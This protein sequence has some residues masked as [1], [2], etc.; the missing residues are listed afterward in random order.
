MEE[1]IKSV[2]SVPSGANRSIWA[3]RPQMATIPGDQ[4]QGRVFLDVYVSE[5]RY[6]VCGGDRALLNRV[7]SV[8]QG[9]FTPL[10]GLQLPWAN[11][12][13]GGSPEAQ[14]LGRVIVECWQGEAVVGISGDEAQVLARV[15]EQLG[16]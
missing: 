13:V 11:E 3:H 9:E 12:P 14:F 6:A 15:R 4:Y 8:L 1:P 2:Q 10:R 5:V 7:R 16:A